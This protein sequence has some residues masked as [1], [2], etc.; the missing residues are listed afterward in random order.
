M[1]RA[2]SDVRQDRDMAPTPSTL[3]TERLLLRRW[4]PE[5][6]NPFAAL[7]ADPVVMEHFVAPL[8]RSESDDLVD[9]IEDTFD[10]EG[11]GLWAVEVVDGSA[12]IGF[13]GL[14]PVTFDAPF[15][16]AVEVGWRLARRGWGSGFAT[17]AARMAVADAFE[18]LGLDEIVSM[19]SRGNTRSQRVMEKVG[20]ARDPA[21][22]FDH[23]N[24]PVD[25]PIRGHVLYRLPRP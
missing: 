5:D 13:V 19:T 23:P 8:S 24:V 16:P 15:T 17:E 12:F 9:R 3:R 14:W 7:N 18:R 25:H 20:M 21:D 6:R 1:A 22:D 10:R 4:R 11:Y 2:T